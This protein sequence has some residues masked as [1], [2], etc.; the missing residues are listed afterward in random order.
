MRRFFTEVGDLV[1]NIVGAVG[2]RLHHDFYSLSDSQKLIECAFVGADQIPDFRLR[3]WIKRAWYVAEFNSKLVTFQE[4]ADFK[5]SSQQSQCRN[6][7]YSVFVSSHALT[8]VY[9]MERYQTI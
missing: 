7:N 2:N 9:P 8:F 1:Q 3:F 6:S 5:L 4:S